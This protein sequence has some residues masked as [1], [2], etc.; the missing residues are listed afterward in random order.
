[1][2]KLYAYQQCN[3]LSV[4]YLIIIVIVHKKYLNLELLT[5]TQNWDTELGHYFT[6]YTT[7]LAQPSQLAPSSTTSSINIAPIVEL[8][9]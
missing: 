7:R 3:T 4:C 1:M 5:G 8:K 6:L 2:L 9:N